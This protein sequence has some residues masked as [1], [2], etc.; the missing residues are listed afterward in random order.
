MGFVVSSFNC[1]CIAHGEVLQHIQSDFGQSAANISLF[2]LVKQ[3]KV[4]CPHDFMSWS[5]KPVLETQVA[6]CENII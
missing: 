4:N 6:Q 1:N 2:N 5:P 3:L